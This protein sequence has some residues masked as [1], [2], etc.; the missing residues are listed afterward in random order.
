M[1]RKRFSAFIL[2]FL[3]LCF[4]SSLYITPG[5]SYTELQL[6]LENLLDSIAVSTRGDSEKKNR[7]QDS[8]THVAISDE[9]SEKTA[10]VLFVLTK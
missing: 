6:L 4:E 1:A 5:V 9:C 3:D 7:A 2:E 10:R 8:I